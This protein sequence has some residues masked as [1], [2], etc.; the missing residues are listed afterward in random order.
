[1]SEET[2]ATEE[3]I[4]DAPIVEDDSIAEDAPITEGEAPTGP[5]LG[6]VDIK[7]AVAVLDYAAEQGAFKGWGTINQVIS[8]RQK[9]VEFV[10][11]AT[12]Q[13]V[14]DAEAAAA[15]EAAGGTASEDAPAAEDAA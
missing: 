8:V 4:E 12:P 15:A 14:K 3:L 7:N 13:E 5:S 10:D 1:M 2:T 11:A 9:L 6:L